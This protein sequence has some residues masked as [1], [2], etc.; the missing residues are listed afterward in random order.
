MNKTRPFTLIELLVVIAII[1]ILAT[2]LLPSLG[3]ARESAKGIKCGN[4]LKG[5]ST[6][7]MMYANDYGMYLT[8]PCR[9]NP[10]YWNIDLQAYQNG[11]TFASYGAD[12]GKKRLTNSIWACPSLLKI[13][14]W[15]LSGYGVNVFLPPA[16]SAVTWPML[17]T[18][19]PVMTKIKSP[20]S[21]IY[22]GD[23]RGTYSSESGDWHISSAAKLSDVTSLFGY[24]HNNRANMLYSDGHLGS[25]NMQFFASA[26]AQ[27]NFILSGS[28]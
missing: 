5:I 13:G 2:L 11:R 21:T 24:V 27:S 25:G 22:C 15:Y 17:N 3:I 4:N 8:A 16:N 7:A 19:Y 10:A 18:I 9:A 14:N 23:S 1:S 26:G 12:E 28:Y 6:V 20:A